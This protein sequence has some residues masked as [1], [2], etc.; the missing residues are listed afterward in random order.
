MSRRRKIPSEVL[1]T[2]LVRS[3]R[4]C[5]LC[6]GLRGDFSERKGQVAHIDHD[7]ANHTERN[8][9]FLCLEHHDAFDSSPSQSKGITKEEVE[10]YRD[11]LYEGVEAKLSR[12]VSEKKD[13]PDE[14]AIASNFLESVSPKQP[15]RS[16]ILNGYEIQ[17]RVDGS[18]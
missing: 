14:L 6:F 5:C 1:T 11:K 16:S 17:K 2:V 8:L 4:R 9:V 10:F 13:V 3:A 12:Q 15:F 18:F 7:P